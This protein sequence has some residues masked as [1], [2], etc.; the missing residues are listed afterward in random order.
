MLAALR[1]AV[2]TAQALIFSFPHISIVLTESLKFQLLIG[3]GLGLG[4][5]VAE[6]FPS[7]PSGTGDIQD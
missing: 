7:I 5:E 2:M 3:A 4:L 1:L 6:L